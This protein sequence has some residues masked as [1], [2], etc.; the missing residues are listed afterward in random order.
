MNLRSL[1]KL[2]AIA[3]GV[4]LGYGLFKNPQAIPPIPISKFPDYSYFIFPPELA[5]A[6]ADTSMP[7]GTLTP[8]VESHMCR[9]YCLN[10]Y[11]RCSNGKYDVDCA[12]TFMECKK[13][14]HEKHSGVVPCR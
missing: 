7:P 9:V 13:A 2:F 12:K 5:A 11:V 3:A 4:A 6:Q 1:V 10:T 8:Y 14:C